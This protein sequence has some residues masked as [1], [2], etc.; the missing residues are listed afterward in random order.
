MSWSRWPTW[1]TSSSHIACRTTN[2]QHYVCCENSLLWYNAVIYAFS[3][4]S[5]SAFSYSSE[6][7]TMKLWC[8]QVPK[9]KNKNI[10]ILHYS[11]SDPQTLKW[12]DATECQDNVHL[13]ELRQR[14]EIEDTVKVWYKEIDCDGM[15]TFWERM[16]TIGWK[17]AM[18]ADESCFLRHFSDRLLSC[19]VIT[20]THCNLSCVCQLEK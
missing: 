20:V 4:D 11:G 3:S 2:Q 9:F 1:P 13:L 16:T 8:R 10:Y 7:Y 6:D 15:D 5:D 17:C 14:L 19:A 18:L 12:V